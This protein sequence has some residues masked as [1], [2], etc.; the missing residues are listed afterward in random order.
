MPHVR[1][2]ALGTHRGKKHILFLSVV[3]MTGAVVTLHIVFAS[4]KI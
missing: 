2:R 1:G 4:S 3:L